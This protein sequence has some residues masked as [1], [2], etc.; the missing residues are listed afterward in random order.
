M[1][2][3]IIFQPLKFRNL[4]V[5]NRLFRSNVSGRFDNYDGSGTQTRI[6]WEE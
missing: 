6:N 1:D 5:K 3:D 4:T 2:Q